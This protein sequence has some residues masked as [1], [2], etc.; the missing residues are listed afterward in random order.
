MLLNEKIKTNLQNYRIRVLLVDDQLINEAAVKKMLISESDIDFF[1]CSEPS[2]AVQYAAEVMPTV[3]LQDIVMPDIDGLMLTKFYRAHS[4]LRDVPII[5]LSGKEEA[6][7]KAKAF[8]LGA[9][10]YLVKF[11]H[12]LELIARIRYHSRGYIN[13]MERNDAYDALLKSQQELASELAK[14]GEYV[15][16]LLPEEID[17]SNAQNGIFTK[18]KYIPSA[19]LGGDSFGYHWIDEDNFAFYLLDVCGHGVGSALLSVSAMNTIRSNTMPNTDLCEPDQVLNALNRTFQ[20]SDHNNLFFTMIYCVYNKSKNVLKYANAGHPPALCIDSDG[21]VVQLANDNF[22]IGG[23]PDFNY[24]ASETELNKPMSIYIFSDGVYEIEVE[25]GTMWKF[26]DFIDYFAGLTLNKEDE[27]E[28]LYRFVKEKV[29]KEVL[30][31]DFSIVKIA[32]E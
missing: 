11:P 6:E 5:V 14:A 29:D 19:Q 2:K 13:L 8:E 3:I 1:F 12:A 30:D 7:T 4:R 10:D 27:L 23:L 24:T 15:M 21:K 17:K 9:N 31:D 32:F 18:W 28:E 22:V 26:E 25:E 20:M 16:S